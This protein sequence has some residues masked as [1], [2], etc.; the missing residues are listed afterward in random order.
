MKIR[1]YNKDE[2]Q[3]KLMKMIEVEEGWDYAAADKAKKYI[4][5]LD[6]SIT[7]VAC[8]GDVL[9]GYSRSMDDCGFFMYVIC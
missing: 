1:S 9:C 8:E 6:N 5:A 7:Y 4:K 3:A 2:D